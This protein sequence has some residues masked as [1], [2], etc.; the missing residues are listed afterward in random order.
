MLDEC[1]KR[2]I[3]YIYNNGGLIEGHTSFNGDKL[4]IICGG[5]MVDELLQRFK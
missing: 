4:E 2:K 3:D 1:L 5:K